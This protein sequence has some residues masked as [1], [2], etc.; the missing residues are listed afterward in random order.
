M[1]KFIDLDT[2]LPAALNKIKTWVN[3]KL[4]T[5]QDTLVS[6]TN[7]KT[8]NNESLLG[9]GNI[10]IQ[11]EKGDKGDK[12]DTGS[13]VVTDGV[14]QISIINDL[15]TGGTGDALSAEMGKFLKMLL[16]SYESRMDAL[17]ESGAVLMNMSGKTLV[18][19]RITDP[20]VLAGNLT[21]SEL[22]AVAGGSSIPSVFFISGRNLESNIGIALSDS[23]NFTLSASSL[24]PVDG[25][26][27]TTMVS[28]TYTPASGAA[29]DTTHNC[30]VVITYD[31]TTQKTMSLSGTVAA[32]AGVSLTP[33]SLNLKTVEGAQTSGTIHVGALALSDDVIL[34]LSGSGLSFDDT[35]SVT[36]KTIARADAEDGIDVTIYYTAGASDVTGS[37]TASSTGV[38]SAT[39]TING[40]VAI[41]LEVG[42]Y[43]DV[44][45]TAGGALRYTVTSGTD[46]SVKGVA[47][48]GTNPTST[49]DAPLTIPAT[50][51][52]G[53]AVAVYNSSGTAIS[54]SNV[55]Y[56]VKSIAADG[57][58]NALGTQLKSIIISEGIT[59][60]GNK[61][62]QMTGDYS[63]RQNIQ[64][65]SFPSTLSS[66][67]SG[68]A[69]TFNN[70]H[71][72]TEIEFKSS[73]GIPP[74]AFANC[75]GITKVV[76]VGGTIEN[77]AFNGCTQ[78]SATSGT[79]PVVVHRATT[80]PT[81]RSWAGAKPF[82]ENSSSKVYATLYCSN[83]SAFS[84]A[85]WNA[86]D[87][88]LDISNYEE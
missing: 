38:T 63:S 61:A 64:R 73:C 26:V 1:Y 83:P 5:K 6:G 81:Y 28:V 48:N 15:A 57:F 33:S 69:Y 41:P 66:I 37:I 8:V 49:L 54:A 32:S 42:S 29:A 47:R 18:I 78:F 39:A 22:N 35:D 12:G 51:N 16:N 62:F 40:V 58:K 44:P 76:L 43:F 71:G 4:A 31:G 56:S 82:P 17:E 60:I 23:T 19:S 55:D 3:T 68:N 14:A 84:A 79:K 10:T 85:G 45:I 36:T 75:T 77:N 11:G 87:E 72:L 21:R 27:V 20:I 46:V 74:Y 88:I 70:N 52:D 34:E 50:I 25:K 7:I 59:S 13:V 9:G 2:G 80:A 30:N 67:G 24:T 86:F 53:D 65:I